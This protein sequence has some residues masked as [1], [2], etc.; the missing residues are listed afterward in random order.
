MG[1]SAGQA[2]LLTITGR[3]SD[4]EFE[5]MRLSHQKIALTRQLVDLSN[6]YQNSLEQ[7]KLIYDFYGTGDTSTQ[8]SYGLLMSPSAL[9]NYMPTLITDSLGRVTLNGKLAKA[10][11]IAGIP[12]EGLGSLPSDAM[13]DKFIEGLAKSG[14]ITDDMKN[15]I[16]GLPYNQNIGFGGGTTVAITTQSGTLDEFCDYLEKTGATFNVTLDR[17]RMIDIDA[18]QGTFEVFKN[19]YLSNDI[20][21]GAYSNGNAT[22]DNEKDF[23][24]SEIL[25]GKNDY[26]VNVYKRSGSSMQD[27]LMEY[28][29]EVVEDIIN[30]LA[31]VF[32]V[33]LD[34][35]DGYT[36]KALEYALSMT[37]SIYVPKDSDGKYITKKYNSGSF[38]N[39]KS[40]Y[41]NAAGRYDSKNYIGWVRDDYKSSDHRRHV[42]TLNFK[43]LIS[44]FL[45]HFEDY[46]G[47]ISKT[48]MYGIQEL[49]ANIGYKSNNLV[50]DKLDHIYTW[51]TGT[52]VSSDDLGQAAFY[53]ALFNQLC[54][55]GWT[56]NEDITKNQYLQEM[57]QSGRLYVSR[58]KD[59]GYYYQGNY[60][61]DSYIKEV[62]DETLIA[63]AEAKYN[64]EKAKLNQKEETLDLK[65]K[66]LDTEISSLTTEYDTVKN[67]ISKNIEKSFKRYNA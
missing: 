43:N 35:G 28:G 16:L 34:L 47:G 63:Q 30:Q 20:V 3:K 51:K 66:N 15:K 36:S 44:T 46:I 2:R 22:R 18:T 21:L 39:R 50:T 33:S 32:A 61:T 5:S 57:L 53:D 13:R 26:I 6:E 12:Q 24:I 29:L 62:A 38:F 7:T 42:A 60:A 49:E 45:T 8:L 31:D 58:T 19:E 10:A 25:K 4:C 17:Q 14:V 67:T 55:K 56:E 23:S 54:A 48:D 41:Y 1:L 59:D 27:N 64:T 11:R 9:N 52:D 37:K 65:M 40:D